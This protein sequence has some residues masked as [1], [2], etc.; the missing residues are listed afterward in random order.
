[1]PPV[2][3]TPLRVTVPVELAPPVT[4]AGFSVKPVRVGGSSVTVVVTEVPPQV[5]IIV[6]DFSEAVPT[7]ETAK[8]AEL[9]PER[10]LTL[11][12]TF[13]PARLLLRSTVAP[14][15]GALPLRLTV[16]VTDAPP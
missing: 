2:G 3:A 14:P 1:M 10:I 16:P 9:W 7:V 11:T 15:E 8:L 4:E 13:T 5:A 6:E 12:G